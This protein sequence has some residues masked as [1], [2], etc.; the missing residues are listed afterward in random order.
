[1]SQYYQ[2]NTN[3]RALTPVSATALNASAQPSSQSNNP[4]KRTASQAKL[5]QDRDRVAR[6]HNFV[7]FNEN[8]FEDDADLDFSESFT[9]LGDSGS[10]HSDTPQDPVNLMAAP[11]LSSSPAT[12]LP[13]SSSPPIS[14]SVKVPR[15]NPPIANMTK[16]R[17][18]PW[19]NEAGINSDDKEDKL[20]KRHIP[21]FIQEKI[22]N[23]K[24]HRDS[25][26]RSN[27]YTPLPKDKGNSKYP[28]NTTASAVKEQQKQ[29]RQGQRKPTKDHEGD[30][31]AKSNSRR[32]RETVAKVFLSDEQK[33][34][35]D[36]VS[37]KS[38]SVFFTGSAGTGKSV[39]LREIIKVFRQKHKREPDRVA[40]TASTGLAACNVGG[41]TL[42][43]FA[44]IGLGKEAVP[45]LVKK[46]KRN[47][48]AKTRWMR[49]KVLIIDEISM[50]DGDLFDKLESIARA[51][52][53]NGR[54]F[55]GIQLV[56]TGD[57]FQLPPVPDYGRVSKFCFDAATWNTSVEHTIGL[58]QVFRQKDPG[59]SHFLL[60]DPIADG[61][62]V[63]QH[64]K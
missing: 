40:V 24:E 33:S 12:P 44:G 16:R 63:R 42:H 10:N 8:D 54:P 60:N 48:K 51:I 37:E 43:S 36:L 5:S 52:R 2:N 6:L 34:V 49:T 1:M 39:L 29:L 32:K 25:R 13:W 30:E 64:V 53:N 46:I 26:A 11:K 59:I 9:L 4:L 31:V 47:Q 56:I 61:R 21:D 38:K 19:V 28:W 45:E 23:V 57:F 20:S 14:Q 58:T 15:Q 50:V 62:S 41:V 22:K 18:L 35:L 55:G 17:T 7:D 3:S 27:K